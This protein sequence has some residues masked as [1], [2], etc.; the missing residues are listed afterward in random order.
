MS[1]QQTTIVQTIVLL[2][3]TNYYN[4]KEVEESLH[5]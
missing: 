4:P 3:G 5:N 2:K 1:A